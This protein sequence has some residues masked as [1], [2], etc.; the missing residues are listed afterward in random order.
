MVTKT[1]TET[2]CI[3]YD[4]KIYITWTLPDPH[5]LTDMEIIILAQL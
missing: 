1:A 2:K 5:T 4:D 3:T